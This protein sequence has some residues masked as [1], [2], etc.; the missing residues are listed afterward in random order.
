MEYYIKTFI[1]IVEEEDKEQV[2]I[3]ERVIVALHEKTLKSKQYIRPYELAQSISGIPNT[4]YA[5]KIIR[6]LV[7]TG[8]LERIPE[9]HNLYKVNRANNYKDI[10]ES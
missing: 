2:K 6:I 1:N 10:L 4:E 7:E 9:K 3:C 5:H 8:W